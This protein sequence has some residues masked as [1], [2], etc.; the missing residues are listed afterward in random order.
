MQN[1]RIILSKYLNVKLLSHNYSGGR[2]EQDS[3]GRHYKEK[4]RGPK[5]E[6]F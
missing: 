6:V 2:E 1:S 4:V 5:F 3:R